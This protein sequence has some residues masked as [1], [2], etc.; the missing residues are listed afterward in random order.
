MPVIADKQIPLTT[1]VPNMETRAAVAEADEISSNHRGRFATGD[2]R[3]DDLEKTAQLNVPNWP[4][5]PSR[6][7]FPGRIRPNCHRAIYR[8]RDVGSVTIRQPVGGDYMFAMFSGPEDKPAMS[9]LRRSGNSDDA[10]AV[11]L[12]VS[13]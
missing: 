10:E 8:F 1:S 13:G 9:G 5:P 12:K 6:V 7:Y 2:E 3:V 11:V 4:I